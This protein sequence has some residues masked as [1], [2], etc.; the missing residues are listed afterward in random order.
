M[1][2]E[3]PEFALLVTF[4]NKNSEKLNGQYFFNW[5]SFRIR[6]KSPRFWRC[7][8]FSLS[9]HHRTEKFVVCLLAASA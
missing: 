6:Q 8:P 7:V 3:E 4:S 1:W 5:L 2:C 9:I